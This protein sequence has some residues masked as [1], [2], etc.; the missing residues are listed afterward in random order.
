MNADAPDQ[1]L[2]SI[3]D[4]LLVIVSDNY[5]FTLIFILLLL[6][7]KPIGG[8]IS[9]LYT[10]KFKDTKGNEVELH[11][12]IRSEPNLAKQSPKSKTLDPIP[13]NE[14]FDLEED[15]LNQDSEEPN[16]LHLLFKA[17]IN[18]EA[19]KAEELFCKLDPSSEDFNYRNVKIQYFYYL[20]KT[21]KR[22]EAIE[23]LKEC[24]EAATTSEEK[25][26]SIVWL[27]N[28]YREL[29]NNEYDLALWEQYKEEFLSSDLCYRFIDQYATTLI[30]NKRGDEA[31]NLAVN[32]L[33]SANA[34]EKNLL[35][36]TLA[37]IE[38]NCGNKRLASYCKDKSVEYG[39]PNEDEVFDAAYSTSNVNNRALSTA[40]YFRLLR[41]NGRHD[42]ALNNIV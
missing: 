9:R 7:R 35:F 17:L 27:S 14:I 33:V 40:N 36:S 13:D 23:G 38:E 42:A 34:L 22:D 15:E 29:L 5:I 1:T 16:Q 19:E 26:A 41:M 30:K 10:L 2:V 28:S 21:S 32:Y 6:Y 24:I 39:I 37:E 12:D 3:T 31:R 20:A 11:A 8:F 25:F 18:R 4:A